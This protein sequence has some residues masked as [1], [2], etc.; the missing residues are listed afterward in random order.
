[1]PSEVA[2]GRGMDW[3]PVC[4]QLVVVLPV[5]R[6]RTFWGISSAILAI[7]PVGVADI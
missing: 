5:N 3:A 1:M 4:A 6:F 2:A 7:M